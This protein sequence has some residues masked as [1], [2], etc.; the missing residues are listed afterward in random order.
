VTDAQQH[1]A[2]FGLHAEFVEE[3]AEVG[4]G[5]F[6][7]DDEAGVDGEFPSLLVHGDR[8]GAAAGAF[9]VK[10]GDLRVMAQVPGAGESRDPRADDADAGPAGGRR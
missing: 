5:D 4:V 8:V 10:E 3:A 7:E 9:P 6:V 1:L 2:R